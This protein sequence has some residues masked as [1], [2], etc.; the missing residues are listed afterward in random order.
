MGKS[1][2]IMDQ[3]EFKS[4][5]KGNGKKFTAER[6]NA[7]VS[8]AAA[9]AAFTDS[10][11][12]SEEEEEEGPPQKKSK[13]AKMVKGPR[14][15]ERDEPIAYTKKVKAQ[16]KSMSVKRGDK[17]ETGVAALSGAQEVEMG[18]ASEKRRLIFGKNT[19]IN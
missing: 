6:Y 9:M 1:K 5:C 2:G 11:T 12:A 3:R 8:K 13:S 4:W 18:T 14:K 17:A 15:G 19:P 10:D 7:Y 16:L